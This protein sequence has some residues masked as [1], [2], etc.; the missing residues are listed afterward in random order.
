M[1]EGLQLTRFIGGTYCTSPGVGGEYVGYLVE[2]YSFVDYIR[3]YGYWDLE[4]GEF[5]VL[6]D[7]SDLKDNFHFIEGM[8]TNPKNGKLMAVAHSKVTNP[9]SSIGE[10]DPETGEVIQKQR[11]VPGLK[12]PKNKKPKAEK[13]SFGHVKGTKK[14]YTW[15]LTKRGYDIERITRRVKKKFPDANEKSISLWFR[16]AKREYKKNGIKIG[17][18]E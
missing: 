4:T 1:T 11:R 14:Q 8:S 17:V 18:Q 16:S 7:M 2:R 13:D 10:V 12:K 9:A 5:E 3:S 6:K 15:E